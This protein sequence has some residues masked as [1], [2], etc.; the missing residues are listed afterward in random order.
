MSSIHAR[1]RRAHRPN[2]APIKTDT[3][4][5]PD[6]S[7]RYSSR[8]SVPYSGTSRSRLNSIGYAQDVM[9]SGPSPMRH[10]LSDASDVVAPYV[11]VSRQFCPTPVSDISPHTKVWPTVFETHARRPRQM[12]MGHGDV[13]RQSTA[14]ALRVSATR[15]ASRRQSMYTYRARNRSMDVGLQ[16]QQQHRLSLWERGHRIFGRPGEADVLVKPLHLNLPLREIRSWS[17]ESSSASPLSR[18]VH[19]HAV[20]NS[21]SRGRFGLTRKFKLEELRATALDPL[22]CPQSKNFN[23]QVLLSR[24]QLSDEDLEPQSPVDLEMA[25]D[26]DDEVMIK[27]EK[28]EMPPDFKNSQPVLKAKAVPMSLQY[29]RSQLPALAAVMLKGEVGRGDVVELAMPHP[30]AWSSTI[31]YVYTGEREL[32]TEEVRENIWYLGGKA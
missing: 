10:N 31:A 9:H 29:V 8:P 32:L 17:K 5:F 3:S 21:K 2:I 28:T 7:R 20:V 19:V 13:F 6:V 16:R 24:L 15:A 1:S 23:R 4:S 14:G 25:D 12:S 30:T 27:K 11:W 22:P 18:R 26:S